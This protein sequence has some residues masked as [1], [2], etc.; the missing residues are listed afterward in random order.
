MKLRYIPNALTLFR[1]ALIAPF[2]YFLYD[3]A[4]KAALYVFL[5]AGLTDGLD[6]WLARTF[7]WQSP[8]GSFADPLADKLL[9][10]SSFISLALLHQVPWWLVLLVFARDMTISI[11]VV[12]W[13]FF[14]QRE[15][16]FKPTLLSKINTTVQLLLVTLCLCQLAFFK[17]NLLF[18]ECLIY[19]T[20][21]TTAITYADYVWTWGRKA[22]FSDQLAK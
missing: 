12:A 17:F 19:L 13:Y 4:Y 2:L 1:L 11:G 7:K 5:L 18:I 16:N 8:F 20:A 6:G 15:L 22:C 14:I 21:F 3:G 10:T 9:V